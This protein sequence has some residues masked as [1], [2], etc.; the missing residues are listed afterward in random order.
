MNKTLTVGKKIA[1]IASERKCWGS[2]NPVS[3]SFAQLFWERGKQLPEMSISLILK[4]AMSSV[5]GFGE[6]L[7]QASDSGMGCVYFSKRLVPVFLFTS[8]KESSFRSS[9]WFVGPDQVGCQLRGCSELETNRLHGVPA[10]L[11]R[12]LYHVNLLSNS[13]RQCMENF[14]SM[15]YVDTI[16]FKT[17]ATKK[18]FLWWNLES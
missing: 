1:F 6:E 2:F 18:A 7:L 11:R 3:M 9:V 17:P 14:V 15:E 4:T 5:R 16:S 13:N 12:Q 10:S 8:R